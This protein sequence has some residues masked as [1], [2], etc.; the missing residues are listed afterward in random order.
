MMLVRLLKGN[1]LLQNL[2][3][4][5]CSL[6]PPFVEH[7]LSKYAALR[8]AFYLT[9]LEGVAGDYLEFGVF[10][11]SS[12][13]AAMRMHR[14]MKGIANL[15]TKFWGFD[16]FQG[17]GKVSRE[18][19]HP[20]YQDTTFAVDERRVIRNIEKHAGGLPIEIVPGFFQNSLGEKSPAER[21]IEKAR[22]I[23]IDC[24]LKEPATLILDWVRPLFQP[25]TILILDDYY[26]YRGSEELGAAGAFKKFQERNPEL[27]LRFLYP[28]GMGGAAYIV[29]KIS[30]GS[31]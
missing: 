2:A 12:F 1:F 14:R 30:P 8:K 28:Y 16:S 11:G 18:D 9:A 17:F 21:G 5:V 31:T 4:W 19:E 22:I 20:F 29:S 15:P 10:T 13:V 27:G 24:D 6:I 3:S 25:G 26:S 23:F 7:N